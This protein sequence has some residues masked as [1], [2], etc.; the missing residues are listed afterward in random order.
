MH[1]LHRVVDEDT[2]KPPCSVSYS[3]PKKQKDGNGSVKAGMTDV[4]LFI[5]NSEFL[6]DRMLSIKMTVWKV[7]W[8]HV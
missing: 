3:I 1:H 5:L 8:N 7:E 2:G 6:H 4:W